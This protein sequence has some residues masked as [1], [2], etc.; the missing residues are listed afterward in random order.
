MSPTIGNIGTTPE[1]YQAWATGTWTSEVCDV[2][3]Q[4]FPNSNNNRWGF[5]K[6]T[7]EN[8]EN[9]DEAYVRIDILDSSDNVLQSDIAGDVIE[10]NS[11]F[12]RSININ[13]YANSRSADIRIKVK[14]YSLTKQPIVSN[15]ILQSSK[16]W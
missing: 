1:K 9:E 14:L 11:R 4:H 15:L 12:N 7:E 5:L 10:G 13:N 8:T 2:S 16:S 6:W 3:K